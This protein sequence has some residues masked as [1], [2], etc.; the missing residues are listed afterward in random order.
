MT[1]TCSRD[2]NATNHTYPR[3]TDPASGRWLRVTAVST[4]TFTVNVGASSADDQY[5]HTF[6]SAT[7][8]GIVKKNNTITVNVGASGPSD[9][10]VHTFVSA[11]SNAVVAGGNYTHTFVSAS[12]GV[13]IVLLIRSILQLNL[14][15][16]HVLKMEILSKPRI[17]VL[18]TLQQKQILEISA[19]TTDTFTINVGASPVGKQYAHTFVSVSSNAVSKTEYDLGDC[20]DV[21]NTVNT[22]MSIIYD[23]LTNATLS[24]AVNHLATVTKLEPI[25]EFVGATVDA[26][27]EVPFDIEFA[28]SVNEVFTNQIDLILRTDLEMLQ[29]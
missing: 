20:V 29:I 7:A 27:L 10:Y 8:N 9:Q 14:L 22:L 24:P 4:D 26:Y 13:G 18:L 16:S 6:V 5:T 11:T 19:T 12:S 15:L 2:L 21:K 28:D 25:Y 3:S 17:L 23:T 1:F